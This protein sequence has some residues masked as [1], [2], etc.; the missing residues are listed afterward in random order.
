MWKFEHPG[1]SNSKESACNVRRPG[2]NPWVG[3][4]P[5][6]RE[7]QPTPVFLPGEFHGLGSLMGYGPQGHK[8][9]D[10]TERLTSTNNINCLSANRISKKE[11]KEGKE[12]RGK[13]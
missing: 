9:S 5:W 8:K 6:I 1:G 7:C 3:K 10:T 13:D 2:F 11:K 4:I 12:G